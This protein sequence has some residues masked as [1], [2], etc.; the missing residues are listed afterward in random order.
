MSS[1][2]E[3]KNP[4]VKVDLTTR[5]IDPPPRMP[6][7]RLQVSQPRTSPPPLTQIVKDTIDRNKRLANLAAADRRGDLID[8]WHLAQDMRQDLKA[9]CQ[10]IQQ[11]EDIIDSQLKMFRTHTSYSHKM[12]QLLDRAMEHKALLEKN[13]IRDEETVFSKITACE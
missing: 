7:K 1:K 12:C 3:L 8:A 10:S 6:L 13:G 9:V 4:G 5:F 11:L 2:R